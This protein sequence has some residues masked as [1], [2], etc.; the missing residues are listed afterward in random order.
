[1][2]RTLV[3]AMPSARTGPWGSCRGLQLRA[4]RSRFQVGA[5]PLQR[6]CAAGLLPASPIRPHSL[7]W[8]GKGAAINGRQSELLVLCAA[9]H[10]AWQ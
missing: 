3:W 8:A 6:E 2:R 7:C 10:D 5:S 4:E 1:M 9:A